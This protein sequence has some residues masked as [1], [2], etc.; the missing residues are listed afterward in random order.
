MFSLLRHPLTHYF[1]G[2]TLN[3]PSTP[4]VST[5]RMSRRVSAIELEEP[6]IGKRTRPSSKISRQVS[7]DAFV[8]PL[9]TDMS[10]K[11]EYSRDSASPDT[12]ASEFPLS[13]PQ[14]PLFP[15]HLA[16]KQMYQHHKMAVQL[17]AEL[18]PMRLILSRL[19][20]H[21]TLNRRGIFNEPV[22]PDKL[23]LPD[24]FKVIK[25][26]MDLGTVKMKL[27]SV[28]YRSC[29]QVVD[30][31]R[32][33]F[34][35][36]MLY[37]PPQNSVHVFA[38]ELL[39]I[40]EEQLEAFVPSL[41]RKAAV[42][43]RL[44]SLDSASTG[45]FQTGAK[46]VAS[47][48]S[49]LRRNHSQLEEVSEGEVASVPLAKKRKKR[50]SKV[51]PTHACQHCE[52]RKCLVCA[53]GCLSMEPTLLICNGSGCSGSR[54]RKG[55]TYYVAPDGTRQYC[56]RCHAGLPSVLPTSSR[57]DACRYKR[58]LLKR[59]NDEEIVEKWLTCRS[60][61]EG[62]HSICVLFN[63][64]TQDPDDFIC[65]DCSSFSDEAQHENVEADSD[66]V[67]SF[68]SGS[69]YPVSM[70]YFRLPANKY[71]A[72]R[73]P[74]DPIS[75]FVEIKVR[76]VMRS[77]SPQDSENTVFVRTISECDRL[78][79]VPDVVRRHFARF[80]SKN[81]GES[82]T[83][84]E[85]R[86]RCLALFQKQDG[87]DVCIFCM[88]VQEYGSD[89]D[90]SALAANQHR[91]VYI[92]YLDSVEYF[93]PRSC[94]TQIYQEVLVAYLATARK[95][96]FEIAHIWACPPLRG[97]SF[98][99]WSHPSSQKTPTRE[100]LINWYHGAISR[101]IDAGVVVDVASLYEAAFRG[102]DDETLEEGNMCVD[103]FPP[104]LDGDFWIEEAVRI[105]QNNIARQR[106]AQTGEKETEFNADVEE[107]DSCCPARVLAK[108]LRE[109]VILLPEAKI[110]RRPVN[111]AALK[112]N[113]YHDIIERPMD[114]GTVYS[115]CLLGEF[116]SLGDFVSDVTLVFS[117]AKK[118]NPPGHMVYNLAE[119]VEKTF[120][121]ELDSLLASWPCCPNIEGSTKSNWERYRHASMSLDA[122]MSNM[123]EDHA[124]PVGRGHHL[125]APFAPSSDTKGH[126]LRVG[127]KDA[128]MHRMVGEDVWLLEKSNKS[129]S[130]QDPKSAEKRKRDHVVEN[131]N[132]KRRQTWLSEEVS[133]AVRRLRTSFFTCSLDP[134]P[135]DRVS[136][137]D[138]ELYSRSFRCEKKAPSRSGIADARHALLEFSQFRNL[139]FNTLRRAKFSTSIL[140]FHL[141][142]KNAPGLQP[143]CTSCG[144]K[145]E[146]VRWHK[147]SRV[148]ENRPP[149]FVKHRNT[150]ASTS[151]VAEELCQDCFPKHSSQHQ[152]IPL[153][154][155]LNIPRN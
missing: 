96:G 144:S 125:G 64:A 53:Q 36:A 66:K 112:L 68:V 31:I 27:H 143:V 117:N 23:N 1:S 123:W 105:H 74:E 37:N 103:S 98:V 52:G 10:P 109:K 17:E 44:Q 35:N 155:S 152:F 138:F 18:Y 91:R 150:S 78:F 72:E 107:E 3:S 51:N 140:L 102:M 47:A 142:N 30:D 108:F 26:P 56:Q 151:F 33:V 130:G 121:L 15:N 135:C 120:F 71:T 132:K 126:D 43:A 65:C 62:V 24:Y 67:F 59:K 60:C 4:D 128:V 8:V 13:S 41:S 86:S 100:R 134:K 82:P 83:R 21:P 97:N 38:K 145:I 5:A 94:R 99:F 90:D 113:D 122:T 95:R 85:Y 148:Y 63:D 45:F 57:S 111:A 87:L 93:R 76:E 115:R 6:L 129:N 119:K 147:C 61:G 141:H 75:R 127:G 101:A 20:F 114:L 131:Q 79:C 46:I 84:V 146:E 28:V 58:D 136:D 55:A 2:M 153:Q 81:A 69:E 22:E 133:A 34:E 29:K 149:T 48:L 32:L 42:T 54:I 106:R 39:S 16:S 154:N 104:L 118:Y 80:G 12:F 88:Y 40:L 14:T 77:L 49:S 19:M 139:E 137:E 9:D 50:G 73:L 7:H 124:S 70:D 92:A 116:A 110:F 11:A 25:H 89:G